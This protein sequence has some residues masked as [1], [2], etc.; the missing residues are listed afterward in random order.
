MVDWQR[1]ASAGVSRWTIVALGGVYVA[2]AVGWAFVLIT[3]GTPTVSVLILSLM[4]GGPGFILLYGGYRLPRIDVHPA[5]YTTVARRCLSGLGVIVGILVLY[6]AQPDA[7]ITGGFQTIAILTALGSAAGFGV[8]IYDGQAKTRQRELEATVEQLKASNERLEQFAYAAS[9]DLQEPLRMV[10]SYLTLV[11]KP[12]GEELTEETR[13][14]LDYAIDGADRMREMINGLLVYSRVETAGEPFEPVELD[15]V[16]E[17]AQ[18]NLQVKLAECDAAVTVDPLPR[19][20]GDA[21]QLRQVFQ[22][23]LDNAITYRGDEPPEVHV[24]ASRNGTA[25]TVSVTDNGVGIDP[26]DHDRIFDVFHRL[27]SR[28]K[29]EGS[30]IGLA[31]CQRIV[32]RHGGDIW[33]ES[34]PGSGTTVSVSFPDA[35]G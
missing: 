22:N 26:A 6:H 13:E 16:F 31:I 33:V 23:L 34:E 3:A 20:R 18:E 11:E 8:G 10:S 7:S 21:R 28:E 30:G 1:F 35:G 27:Y 24:S 4:I 19:V 29:Y 15:A 2:L 12:S 17:D 14:F 32:E 5:F 9:H 25:W